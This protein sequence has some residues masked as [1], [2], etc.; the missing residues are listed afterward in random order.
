MALI[1]SDFRRKHFIHIIFYV[2]FIVNLYVVY[3][4]II[5]VKV[6]RVYESR[7]SCLLST[8]SVPRVH[9]RLLRNNY[10]HLVIFI[11]IIII[12][13]HIIS[14]HIL[15][16]CRFI[17]LFFFF[18]YCMTRWNVLKINISFSNC[19][20]NGFKNSINNIHL[21]YGMKKHFLCTKC[22]QNRLRIKK[23]CILCTICK[24]I[25]NNFYSVTTK[26]W[27]TFHWEKNAIKLAKP[28]F[29]SNHPPNDIFCKI[30]TIAEIAKYRLR[31]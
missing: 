4:C 10:F 6:D 13:L 3:L 14:W 5:I 26:N 12:S 19:L 23:N 29:K 21:N 31:K 17:N 22:H 28:Y 25:I 7:L 18:I 15:D 30:K 20:F 2:Q 11:L 8:N 9:P 27:N 16:K 24:R 1:Q